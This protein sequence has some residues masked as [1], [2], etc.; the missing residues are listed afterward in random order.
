[1]EDSL[2]YIEGLLFVKIIEPFDSEPRPA[3]Y[4][5]VVLGSPTVH[6][7][8]SLHTGCERGQT[9]VLAL[10]V[11]TEFTWLLLVLSLPFFPF[12]MFLLK[13]AQG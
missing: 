9:C 4:L 3:Y 2:L 8:S 1:M 5:N 6:L 13:G 10:Q 11:G 12:H 7:L